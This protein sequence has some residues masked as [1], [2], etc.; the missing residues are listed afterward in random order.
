MH[1]LIYTFYIS[2]CLQILTAVGRGQSSIRMDIVAG[3]SGFSAGIHRIMEWMIRNQPSSFWAIWF[4]SSMAT[5]GSW[6]LNLPTKD[7]FI[8]RSYRTFALC[9]QTY[10][11]TRLRM[12]SKVLATSLSM[13]W[14]ILMIRLHS[15]GCKCIPFN[16]WVRISSLSQGDIWSKSSS[17][18]GMGCSKSRQL[19]SRHST[20]PRFSILK[21]NQSLRPRIWNPFSSS[22]RFC[23]KMD[24]ETAEGWIK[25][26]CSPLRAWRDSSSGWEEE[27]RGGREGSGPLDSWLVE[28]EEDEDVDDG[29]HE[30]HQLNIRRSMMDDRRRSGYQSINART[31]P[32]MSCWAG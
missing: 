24:K 32:I 25:L 20:S 6:S 26:A 18:N 29:Q 3:P 11:S 23:S 9:H 31:C 15:S 8:S 27:D 10:L 14:I 16:T 19:A 1:P 28:E 7:P 22:S 30:P 5:G 17:N 13:D 2:N 4:N 21:V 12:D